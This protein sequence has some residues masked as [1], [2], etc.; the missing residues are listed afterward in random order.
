MT[1]RIGTES[2][3]PYADPLAARQGLTFGASK[4]SADTSV[5]VPLIETAEGDK[6]PLD[7][8][9]EPMV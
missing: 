3:C 9:D 2:R 6:K 5:S 8:L 4:R 7:L 1:G